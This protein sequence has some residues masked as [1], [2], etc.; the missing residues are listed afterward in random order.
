MAIYIKFFQIF[1]CFII[2]ILKCWEEKVI[3]VSQMMMAKTE[4]V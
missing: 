4:A 1:G 3:T 2:F